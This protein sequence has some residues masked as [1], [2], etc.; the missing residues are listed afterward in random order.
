M[1]A[2]MSP[3]WSEDAMNQH[4]QRHIEA[5]SD[6]HKSL[7]VDR[8]RLRILVYFVCIVGVNI[9]SHLSAIPDNAKIVIGLTSLGVW[10]LILV[11]SMIQEWRG[12]TD[13]AS[14]G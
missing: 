6:S 7:T 4:T 3:G 12:G 9:G 8:H 2:M 1:C 5:F 10:V 11:R 14:R 13:N